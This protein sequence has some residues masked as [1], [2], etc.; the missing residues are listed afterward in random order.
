MR[1]NK[2]YRVRESLCQPAR[3]G[4]KRDLRIRNIADSIAAYFRY[5]KG[6]VGNYSSEYDR[7]GHG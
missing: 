5:E 4:A 1:R 6:R 2:D 3:K 7:V